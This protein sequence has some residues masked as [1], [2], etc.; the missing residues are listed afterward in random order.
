MSET[1]I[2]IASTPVYQSGVLLG[3]SVLA[4]ELRNS[5]NAATIPT[6]AQHTLVK[7]IWSKE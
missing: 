2:P 1:V 6:I 4:E 3:Q 5:Q 7:A